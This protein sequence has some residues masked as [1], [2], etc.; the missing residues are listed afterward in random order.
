MS[1]IYFHV[2]VRVLERERERE[3]EERERERERLDSIYYGCSRVEFIIFQVMSYNTSIFLYT[4]NFFSWIV[5][6]QFNEFYLND[7][8]VTTEYRCLLIASCTA[9]ISQW[10][11]ASGE[12]SVLHYGHRIIYVQYILSEFYRAIARHKI[13]SYYH[14]LEIQIDSLIL[15]HVLTGETIYLCLVFL[16]A[17]FLCP[18]NFPCL[19]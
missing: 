15:I 2:H 10:Y 18:K 1:E 19:Y 13:H 17:Y 8:S 7:I 4:K 9:P 14:W 16:Y 6:F 3:R 11:S 12:R 5:L